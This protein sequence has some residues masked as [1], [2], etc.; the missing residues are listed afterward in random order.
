[1]NVNND[2][3]QFATAKEETVALG[4]TVSNSNCGVASGNGER[5]VTKVD[6]RFGEDGVRDWIHIG[7]NTDGDGLARTRLKTKAI[8]YELG[9]AL[10]ASPPV[11]IGQTATFDISRRVLIFPNDSEVGGAVRGVM[12]K[13][14]AEGAGSG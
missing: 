1:M 6:D 3:Y 5:S 7:K 4:L 11:C 13:D 14:L 2:D 8:Y 12:L 10:Q 9:S